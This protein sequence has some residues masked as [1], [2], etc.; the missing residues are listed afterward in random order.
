MLG[1]LKDNVL[2]TSPCIRCSR[3]YIYVWTIAKAFVTIGCN[4][5]C[6]VKFWCIK[7]SIACCVTACAINKNSRENKVEK[8]VRIKSLYEVQSLKSR[9]K[10]SIK[11]YD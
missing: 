5:N 3:C 4:I 10:I 6:L 1:L 2:S 11:F 9:K 7:V 8:L